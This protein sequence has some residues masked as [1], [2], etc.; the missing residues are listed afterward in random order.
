MAEG[1]IISPTVSGTVKQITVEATGSQT[2]EYTIYFLFGA[3]DIALISRLVLKVL[4]A[5]TASEFVRLVYVLTGVFVAPFQ[6]IFHRGISPGIETASILEP[7]TIVAIVVYA[8]LAWGIVKLVRIFSG[9]Q[10]PTD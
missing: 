3:L 6:G 2:I 7:A 10:Q 1:I 4:G 8:V 5:S 9:E